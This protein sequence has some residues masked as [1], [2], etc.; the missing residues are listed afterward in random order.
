MDN[1]ILDNPTLCSTQLYYK[2][3][4][5]RT[6]KLTSVNS[7][8][9]ITYEIGKWIEPQE[10]KLFIF[11]D[12]ESARY[13]LENE[14]DGLYTRIY[15]CEAKNVQPAP[16]MILRPMKIR[17]LLSVFW[18]NTINDSDMNLRHVP[19]GSLVCDSLRL[20]ESI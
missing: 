8:H 13:F 19:S 1:P 16:T 12:I 2:V 4:S 5:T 6:G 3:L 10:G 20:I 15:S 11:K 18:N 9:K 14:N 7:W 17:A